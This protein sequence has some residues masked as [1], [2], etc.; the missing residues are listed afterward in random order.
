MVTILSAKNCLSNFYRGRSDG[1]DIYGVMSY[2]SKLSVCNDNWQLNFLNWRMTVKLKYWRIL[3]TLRLPELFFNNLILFNRFSI[4]GVGSAFFKVSDHLNGSTFSR[5]WSK[6]WTRWAAASTVSTT[7]K[8][9]DEAIQSA[10]KLSGKY[11]LLLYSS[12]G[13]EI[14]GTITIHLCSNERGTTTHLQQWTLAGA[15]WYNVPLEQHIPK[16]VL[17]CKPLQE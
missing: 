13:F 15:L 7:P 12:E 3:F 4:R 16:C 11:F 1:Q 10:A 6:P 14:I 8:P 2:T 5:P 9:R 17:K